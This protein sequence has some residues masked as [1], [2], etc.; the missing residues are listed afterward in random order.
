MGFF[1]FS[2]RR[3]SRDKTSKPPSSSWGG[4]YYI[5]PSASASASASSSAAR[6][7]ATMGFG[8][9]DYSA[10]HYANRV[11]QTPY[12][13]QPSSS[14]R[15]S[16]RSQNPPRLHRETACLQDLSSY[17]DGSFHVQGYGQLYS[18]RAHAA[19]PSSSSFVPPPPPPGFTYDPAYITPAMAGYVAAPMASSSSSSRCPPSASRS[20]FVRNRPST[21]T[22]SSSRPPS[23]RSR[24]QP[25]ATPTHGVPSLSRH[26][27]THYSAAPYEVFMSAQYAPQDDFNQMFPGSNSAYSAFSGYPSSNMAA[28]YY[29]AYEEARPVSRD[30]NGVSPLSD[31]FPLS[32][33][34]QVSSNSS[35]GYHQRRH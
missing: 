9:Q 16:S 12:L 22:A 14:S 17:D 35:R 8:N 34:R 28:T 29:P 13:L 6:R 2:S 33:H 10:G 19:A 7:A 5:P 4:N 24:P 3:S 32:V 15:S 18:A 21:A 20:A 26:A 25:L 23:S 27:S 30:S 11:Q 1:G 31:T